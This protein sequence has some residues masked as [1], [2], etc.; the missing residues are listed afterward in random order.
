MHNGK[1]L[2]NWDVWLL[3]WVNALGKSALSTPVLVFRQAC[4]AGMI[5][6][7]GRDRL[8][9]CSKSLFCLIFP[10]LKAHNSNKYFLNGDWVIDL[11]RGYKIA[12]TKVYY[13]RPKRN[14][15]FNEAIVSDGPTR[16]ALDLMV[17]NIHMWYF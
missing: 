7:W 3:R 6:L 13:K 16:E 2:D 9:C 10:A 17:R 14:Q 15:K 4:A 5:R 1:N 12:D 8:I 11:P